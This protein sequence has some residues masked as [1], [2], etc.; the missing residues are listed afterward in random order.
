MFIGLSSCVD[1]DDTAVLAGR[2][3]GWIGPTC[4]SWASSQNESSFSAT[5][6]YLPL[7]SSHP[8]PLRSIPVAN[9]R[10]SCELHFK[11]EKAARQRRQGRGILG[12]IL[13]CCGV[14]MQERRVMLSKLTQIRISLVFSRCGSLENSSL[15]SLLTNLPLRRQV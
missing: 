11:E 3:A 4:T 8:S 15:V 5:P 10:G 2:A 14:L 9:H 1:R 6:P 13:R 12:A 7:Y